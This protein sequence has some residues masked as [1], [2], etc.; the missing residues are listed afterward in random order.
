ME[1]LLTLFICGSYKMQETVGRGGDCPVCA[2]RNTVELRHDYL[3]FCC[4][5]IPLCKVGGD[6]LSAVCRACGSRMPP[7][8]LVE[9][10]FFIS[11]LPPAPIPRPPAASPVPAPAPALAPSP[12]PA[13]ALTP[14]SARL[15]PAAAE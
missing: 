15:P 11:L 6:E 8:A 7:A 5:F 1:L 3:R 12:L 13:L 4:Y 9:Q 14:A 10:P 2:R